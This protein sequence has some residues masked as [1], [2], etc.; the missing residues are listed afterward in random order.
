MEKERCVFNSVCIDVLGCVILGRRPASVD[1]VM[2]RAMGFDPGRIRH[3]VE[4][5]GWGRGSLDPVV[6]GDDLESSVVEFREPS[7]LRASALLG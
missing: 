2:A 1:A 5:A 7:G 4:A 3:V 6:V